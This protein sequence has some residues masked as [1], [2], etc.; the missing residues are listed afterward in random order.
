MSSP[1]AE[2]KHRQVPDQQTPP[3]YA[4]Q[5]LPSIAPLLLSNLVH[6]TPLAPNAQS[7]NTRISS[8]TAHLPSPHLS[9]IHGGANPLLQNTS[10][11]GNSSGQ[12]SHAKLSPIAVATPSGSELRER[13]GLEL[14]TMAEVG[15]GAEGSGRDSGAANNGGTPA[16][17]A[18]APAAGGNKRPPP[19]PL[20]TMRA[21]R[22]CLNCR[23][24]KS[25]CDLDIN[26]GRPVGL[27]FPPLLISLLVLL[28]SS[29]V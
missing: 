14:G 22:A 9:D 15:M 6:H 17:P 25:K 8:T 28:V 10:N 27:I 20:D 26:Q 5:K 2:Y 1:V 18:P 16:A 19:P 12:R 11:A 24:R 7:T 4:G 21:Y 3:S 29:H 23:G 13:Q